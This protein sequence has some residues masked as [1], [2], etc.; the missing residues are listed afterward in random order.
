MSTVKAVED[1]AGNPSPAVNPNRQASPPLDVDGE[2]GPLTTAAVKSF[3][4]ANRLVV[5]GWAGD[6][7]QEK[8][9]HAIAM[10]DQP[11]KGSMPGA[12]RSEA[13]FPPLGL[14]PEVRPH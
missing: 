12:I 5:D 6:K 8:L 4:Q 13:A 1:N 3:Q 11:Q 7:T 9:Q 2:N 10:H 14:L